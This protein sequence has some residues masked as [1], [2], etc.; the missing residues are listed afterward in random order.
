MELNWTPEVIVDLLIGLAF[1]IGGF[2]SFKTSS[3]NKIKTLLFL[4]LVWFCLSAYFLFEGISYLIL[5]T[6]LARIFAII[7][8]PATIFLILAINY[9]LKDSFNS[10][11]LIPI[12]ILGTLLCYLAFQPDAVKIVVEDG[13]LTIVWTGL[14]NIIGILFLVIFSS[15]FFY[16]A[17]KT[18]IHAPFEIKK[19]ASL[20]LFGAVIAN[21]VSHIFYFLIFWIPSFILL[22][23]FSVLIG[24]SIC[25]IIIKK[26][27]KILYILPF[28]PYRIIVY[29]RNGFPLFDYDWTKSNISESLFSGFI[30]SI[31]KMSKEIIN[32]GGLLDI[33][34]KKGI[35][36]LHDS[37]FITVG[38]VISKSSKFLIDSIKKF[39][40]EFE[41]KFEKQLIES[42]KDTSKFEQANLLIEKYF[43]I[44]PSRL[45]SKNNNDLFL[46]KDYYKIPPDLDNI[47]K[48]ILKDEKE[49]EYIK[50]E[51]QRS[52]KRTFSEFLNLYN[53]LIEEI[54]QLNKENFK[55][56]NFELIEPK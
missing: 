9:N 14:F 31:Q 1:L 25:N 6:F 52:P 51:I 10:I 8:F 50:C 12:F 45:I 15:C 23:N 55:E 49:Y 26:E 22:S 3:N 48:K 19:E 28:T 43:S 39:S 17:L 44:F 56:S 36:I 53:E 40:Y 35:L 20:F 16:W 54:Y 18:W 27:P 42:C 33:R 21:I 2:F 7:A 29:D 5:S 38:L 34:L 41:E 24:L 37:K 11:N 46:S 47:L 30:I 13:Y 32:M 4:R